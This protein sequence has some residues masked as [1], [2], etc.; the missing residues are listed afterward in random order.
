M[1]ELDNIWD[2]NSENEETKS[3]SNF[4]NSLE[5]AAP[6]AVIGDF[7]LVP[8][9]KGP[10]REKY[11]PQRFEEIAPTCSIEQIRNQ[12]N[13][14]STSQIYLFEGST[15][16][17]KTTCA[18]ILAKAINCTAA[19]PLSRPCLS[20]DNCS[21]F[22]NS[23]DKIE[24]NTANK[25]KVED[26][27]QLVDDMRYAPARYNKKVYILDEVQRLTSDAQQVLLTEL[28]EPYP[29]LLVFLCTTNIK[30]IDKALVDRACRV[31]FN[32]L[33]PSQASD[34][35][36]QVFEH[37]S[38]TGDDDLI[39]NLFYQ[40]N[41]SVRAL[42]NNIEAYKQKG[43]DPNNWSEDEV[44]TE[45]KEL[46]SNLKSGDWEKLSKSLKK[47]NVR[48]DPEKLRL[49][50]ECYLRGVILNCAS[51]NEA[52]KLGEALYRIQGSLREE[53]TVSQYNLFVLK[54]LRASRAMR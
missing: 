42:L 34:I 8:R 14:P 21:S 22:E 3:L 36:R 15:G 43:F 35:T 39:E 11:R 48:K 29:Y 45:V 54:C 5:K 9:G 23:Y 44:T 17:G 25:N 16:T 28:E 6:K 7:R 31:T 51:I 52:A 1:S 47:P 4:V 26:I 24:L 30:K 32:P 41:G 53:I 27:R 18:R 38:L 13:N 37:E 20:C 19:N 33:T 12:V 46:F 40:S 2:S 49:G 50:L 10:F